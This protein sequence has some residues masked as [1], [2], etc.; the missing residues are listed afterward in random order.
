MREYQHCL[1]KEVRR[2]TGYEDSRGCPIIEGDIVFCIDKFRKEPDWLFPEPEVV[3]D[4]GDG[5]FD[6]GT[7]GD[8]D[9]N[10]HDQFATLGDHELYV[11]GNVIDNGNC[12]PEQVY[13]FMKSVALRL[14]KI[15]KG[16]R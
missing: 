13:L 9:A 8:A 14:S 12:Y 5:F 10:Y 2:R 3:V 7:N 15:L 11:I 1:F 6:L 4:N 16:G